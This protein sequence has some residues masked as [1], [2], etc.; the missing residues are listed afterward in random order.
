MQMRANEDR[1]RNMEETVLNMR[2]TEFL[3]NWEVKTTS[4]IEQ[5]R[6]KVICTGRM[7]V[8]PLS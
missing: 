1:I 7:S 4:K 8:A 5:N 6:V 2:K 3:T